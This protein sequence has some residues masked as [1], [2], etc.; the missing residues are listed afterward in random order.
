MVCRHNVLCGEWVQ[1]GKGI[2]DRRRNTVK[3]P[4]F[5]GKRGNKGSKEQNEDGV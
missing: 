2:L 4:G 3:L 1:Q 5:A